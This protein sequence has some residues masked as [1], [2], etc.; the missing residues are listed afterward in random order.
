MQEMIFRGTDTAALLRIA[1]FG[2]GRR[3]CPGKALGLSTVHLWV[4]KLLHISTG[5]NKSSTPWTCPRCLARCCTQFTPFLFLGLISI[6][7]EEESMS[8]LSV[9]L[10]RSADMTAL[11]RLAPTSLR[12]NRC[13]SS[14]SLF[15]CSRWRLPCFAFR[16]QV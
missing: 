10:F 14:V 6:N 9:F 12:K 15:S 1:P 3:V 11:L 16:L 4:A 8:L 7:S 5:F 13:P 2:A